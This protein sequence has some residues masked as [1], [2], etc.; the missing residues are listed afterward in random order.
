MLNE[1]KIVLNLVPGEVPPMAHVTQDDVG[2]EIQLV[3][4]DGDTPFTL[5][6][7]YTYSLHG[8]KP[9][10]T[11]F[12]YDDIVTVVNQNTLE[13]K[14]TAQMTVAEGPVR[15]GLIIYSGDEHIETLNFILMVQRAALGA[16]TI[17]DSSDFGSIITDAVAEWMDD[18][19]VVIDD[20]LT[21]A[22]AA[23][24]AKKT[25]DEIDDL[26]SQIDASGITADLKSAMLDIAAHTG[27]ID[28]NG[29]TYYANLYNA[30]Y[31]RYWQV[32]ATLTGCISS[33]GAEQTVK[34]NPYNA[35]ITARGGYSL[36]G[37]A[38]YIS[39]GGVDITATAYSNGTIS[40]PAVT[41]ALVITITA[42][43][44]TVTAISATFTQGSAAI[45]ADNDLDDLR[46]FLV[47]TGTLEDE[48][49]VTIT[50]Y[51]LSGI[52]GLA[53][54]TITATFRSLTDTFTVTVTLKTLYNLTAAFASSGT[55][56][57]DT[58]VALYDAHAVTLLCDA[59]ATSLDATVRMIYSDRNQ[60]VGGN[61]IQVQKI[62]SGTNAGTY[63]WGSGFGWG[64]SKNFAQANQRVRFVLIMRKDAPYSS[65]WAIKNVTSGT[66]YNGVNE[67][68]GRGDYPN[69][70]NDSGTVQ[71]GYARDTGSGTGFIGTV[72]Q[73]KMIAGEI[74][75]A[76]ITSFFTN[77]TLP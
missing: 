29:P 60:N 58:G 61:A 35:T 41:G 51:T 45:Y 23:A 44:V 9:S 68:A 31:Y 7:S 64:A 18:H 40:I 72:H 3:L 49:E 21:V 2:R 19:G 63:F 33:N 39:M 11:G 70:I 6:S 8:T 1:Q 73:F 55:N 65:K 28:Q 12:A 37:A 15:C 46:Q 71:L 52:L 62:A 48:S 74:S 36:T 10:G 77:G 25:G 43:E 16:E 47:V 30:L 69:N 66:S 42:V 56:Y 76:Q 22:G 17:I 20:T 53:T 5:S 14:T 24:D 57:L 4:I 75:D 54:S 38:V 50:D 27:Y 67:D 26:K 13:F 32:T 34:G 59:T